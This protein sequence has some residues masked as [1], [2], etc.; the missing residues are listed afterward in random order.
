[1]G[2]GHI[3]GVCP[4]VVFSL[5]LWSVFGCPSQQRHFRY[6]PNV[7]T[8]VYTHLYAHFHTNFHT[9]VYTFSYCSG[10]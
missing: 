10:D 3:G 7:Y 8:V 1:M 5:R 6:N 9:Y 4:G 2:R